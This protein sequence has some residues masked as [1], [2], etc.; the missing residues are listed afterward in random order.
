MSVCCELKKDGM[1]ICCLRQTTENTQTSNYFRLFQRKLE[2]YYC[3]GR[4]GSVFGWLTDGAEPTFLQ[5]VNMFWKE[6]WGAQHHRHA[7]QSSQQVGSEVQVKNRTLHVCSKKLW[8]QPSSAW[9]NYGGVLNHKWH[10][11]SVS[12]P[13]AQTTFSPRNTNWNQEMSIH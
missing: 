8:S 13:L 9:I 5:T 7:N 3:H 6:R 1:K 11:S 4:T 2:H 10:N 12:N